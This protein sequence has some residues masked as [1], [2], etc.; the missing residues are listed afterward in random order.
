MVR[1]LEKVDSYNFL[2]KIR[3]LN[4]DNIHFLKI[5]YTEIYNDNY[6][7]YS[8]KTSQESLSIF[9]GN[10]GWEIFQYD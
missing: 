2:I 9:L 5:C 8:F 1:K 4:R 3:S 6:Y 7:I 10:I